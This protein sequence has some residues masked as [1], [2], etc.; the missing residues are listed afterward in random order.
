MNSAHAVATFPNISGIVTPRENA[1][2]PIINKFPGRMGLDRPGREADERL[3]WGLLGGRRMRDLSEAQRMS[4]VI[5]M[6]REGKLAVLRCL[7]DDL[8]IVP[9]GGA[10]DERF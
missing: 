5:A 6:T 7:Q 1:M 10:G 4:A 2:D 8:G 3:I 9:L